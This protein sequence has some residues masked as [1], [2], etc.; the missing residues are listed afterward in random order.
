VQITVLVLQN[1]TTATITGTVDLWNAAGV[2]QAQVPFTMASHQTFIRNT[3]SDAPGIAGSITI[4][5]DGRYG[6]LTGKATA[7]EPSTGFTFD[8]PLVHGPR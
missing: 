7:V 2:L 3:S 1:P 5:H 4:T 6:E 8:T